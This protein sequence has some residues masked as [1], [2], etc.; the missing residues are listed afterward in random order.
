MED[1]LLDVGW[2]NWLVKLST[3]PVMSSAHK[4]LI[5]VSVTPEWYRRSTRV[6]GGGVTCL[7]REG[8]IIPGWYDAL[9]S[10]RNAGLRSPGV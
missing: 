9:S 6:S 8:V 4:I 10:R 1:A 2:I 3:V 5:D 7:S